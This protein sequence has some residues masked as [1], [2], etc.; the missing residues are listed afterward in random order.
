MN[1]ETAKQILAQSITDL[2]NRRGQITMVDV[3]AEVINNACLSILKN[4]EIHK[5]PEYSSSFTTAA[6]QL[7]SQYSQQHTVAAIMAISQNV[8]WE[9]MWNFLKDYFQKNHG[10]QIDAVATTP[11]IFYS[12]KHKRYENGNLITESKEK[13]IININFINDKKEI[14]I[15]IEP[16]LSPKKGYVIFRNQSAIQFKGFDPDYLFTITFD[17]F[18]EVET[19]I[20]EMPNRN[21]KIIY[22]E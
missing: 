18:D 7:I 15:S 16:S 17:F 13:R 19:F 8:Q 9:G 22:V 2:Q 1:L 10:I 3:E 4:K 6:S 5:T 14:L 20:L 21:L 12:T 11:T